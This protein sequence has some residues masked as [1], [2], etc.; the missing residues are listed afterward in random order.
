ME[1]LERRI[2]V[3]EYDEDIKCL[4]KVFESMGIVSA[5]DFVSVSDLTRSNIEDLFDP[6]NN[7]NLLIFE[8][9][10]FYRRNELNITA[11]LSRFR[12]AFP[13]AKTLAIA[14]LPMNYYK[15]KFGI[16]IEVDRYMEK[17]YRVQSFIETVKGLLGLQN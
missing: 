14:S 6:R 12:E 3:L 7:Y 15:V 10:Y 16:S 13:V 1:Q 11:L 5:V 9:M 2:L 8:P 17:V 4:R